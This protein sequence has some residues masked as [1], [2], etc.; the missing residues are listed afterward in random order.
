MN[1]FLVSCLIVGVGV[2]LLFNSV[3]AKNEEFRRQT[4]VSVCE[5]K[6]FKQSIILQG[7]IF[8]LDKDKHMIYG[9]EQ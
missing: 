2:G 7:A 9:G 5:A 1:W 6:G 4:G 3:I 8:C